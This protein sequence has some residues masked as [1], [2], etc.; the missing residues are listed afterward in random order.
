MP[1]GAPAPAAQPSASAN[2]LAK[3]AA[4]VK[5]NLPEGW[6]QSTKE[7]TWEPNDISLFGA[8]S[9]EQLKEGAPTK[10]GFVP[11]EAEVVDPGAKG[12]DVNAVIAGMQDEAGEAS[13]PRAKAKPKADKPAEPAPAEPEVDEDGIP[14]EPA[15][16]EA[17]TSTE[18]VESDAAAKPE[19]EASTKEES[20][21]MI[22]RRAIA[23]LKAE[24]NAR[25]LE[26]RL[27]AEQRGRAN[28]QAEWERR[29]QS[30]QDTLEAIRQKPLA[31][32]LKALG[33]DSQEAVQEAFLRGELK[34]LSETAPAA[35]AVDTDRLARMETELAVSRRDA[36]IQA[37]LLRERSATTVDQ[38]VAEAA[39]TWVAG[40]SK[41]EEQ[42]AHINN[43]LATLING[44]REQTSAM[45]A[46]EAELANT[47]TYPAPFV[48]ALP[49][50]MD[51]VKKTALNLWR[52]AGSK[53][54][55]LPQYT[56]YAVQAAEEVLAEQYEPLRAVF[57]VAPAA[58]AKPGA[59]PF[60]GAKPKASP[61]I[62]SRVA[63]AA[64]AD[65]DEGPMDPA[66]RQAWVKEQMKKKGA[67]VP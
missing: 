19:A 32:R 33:I 47:A 40:G 55:A 57:G 52:E 1:K 58:P 10:A 38:V 23:A 2:P 64:P 8:K 20:S 17:E 39:R 7:A 18:E 35:P 41:P 54:G 29:S 62:G 6:A 25:T 12:P 13:R 43:A 60:P 46:I 22:R 63:A 66:L 9:F 24:A 4:A 14:I 28:D 26:E 50:Q 11:G 61:P 31:E 16:V 44:E 51:N 53:K 48:R 15:S 45:T 56:R 34:D 36:S 59:K 27:A 67:F 42:V 21:S 5:S 37:V 65:A 3:G 30:R 49:G